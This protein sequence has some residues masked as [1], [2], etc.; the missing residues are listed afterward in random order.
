MFEQ[1]RAYW[2]S[3]DNA[4]KMFSAASTSKD[5]RV[6]R[7]Y[8]VLKEQI[9]K[10]VYKPGQQIPTEDYFCD[11]YQI[12]RVT[13]RKAISILSDEG[14]VIKQQGKGTFVTMSNIV[15]SPKAH[16]S[17]TLSCKQNGI[18]PSTKIIFCQVVDVTAD[19]AKDQQSGFGEKMI[20]IK[21]LRCANDMPVILETDY[22]PYPQH[23]YLIDMQLENTSL[24]D[25]IYQHS[26]L[27]S[28]SR[29]D[30]IDI[31]F[32]SEEEAEHLECRKSAPLVHIY[33][34]ILT[35][36]EKILYINEQL[37]NSEHYKYTSV[38]KDK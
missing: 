1:K 18:E 2:R 36:D 4:G 29:E 12:S 6:F 8:C 16:G 25:T 9:D 5:T 10:G 37:I 19:I 7:F 32:A 22:I 20:C 28:A 26:G 27:S 15:E 21:R 30:I 33:Q 31:G 23:S 3:L 34:K 14:A 35:G 11:K 17:F 24:L 38:Y 13:V